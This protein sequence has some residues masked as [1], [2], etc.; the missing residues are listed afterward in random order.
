MPALALPIVLTDK[1]IRE[2]WKRVELPSNMKECW[3]WM[4]AIRKKNGYA[5]LIV[6]KRNYLGHRVSAAIFGV[7]LDLILVV[8]H[9]CRVRHC[10]NPYHFEQITRGENVLI[11][12]GITAV[13]AQKATCPQGHLYTPSNTY[14]SPR[15]GERRC[16]T[17]KKVEYEERKARGWKPKS[18]SHL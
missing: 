17:C 16:K 6:D 7:K 18:Q 2:F 4:G 1:L 15:R 13:N 14:S 5:H 8:N 12:E 10:V 11:G 3:P 9:E